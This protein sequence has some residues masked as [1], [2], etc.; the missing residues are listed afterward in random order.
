MES[1]KISL[2]P[3]KFK[4]AVSDLLK[5]KPEQREPKNKKVRAKKNKRLNA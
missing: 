1:K 2:R 3:L 5:I 4:E